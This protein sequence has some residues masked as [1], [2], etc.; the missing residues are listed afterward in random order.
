[1]AERYIGATYQYDYEQGTWYL[2]DAIGYTG[3]VVRSC[4]DAWT[5]LSHLWYS[6][7]LRID[8]FPTFAIF[9]HE[10]IV[11]QE[12]LLNQVGWDLYVGYYKGKW[13][14]FAYAVSKTIYTIILSE[15]FDRRLDDLNDGIEREY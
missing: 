1:M 13:K 10:N 8:E 15:H 7:Y 12:D 5:N 4:Y 9:V 6:F 14:D 11:S 2:T 3:K